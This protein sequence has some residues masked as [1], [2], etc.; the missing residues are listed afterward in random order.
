VKAADGSPRLTLVSQPVRLGPVDIEEIAA[1]AFRLKVFPDILAAQAEEVTLVAR[2]RIEF[3]SQIVFAGLQD[4]V[5]GQGDQAGAVGLIIA[6][7]AQVDADE[8]PDAILAAALEFC[9]AEFAYI[10]SRSRA[11]PT[12]RTETGNGRATTPASCG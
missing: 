3:A 9:E 1:E 5:A 11:W 7:M 12:P 4:L 10:T 8:V 2:E 6:Q